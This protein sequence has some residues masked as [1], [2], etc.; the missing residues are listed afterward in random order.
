VEW[1]W[2]AAEEAGL[3]GS[4]DISEHYR[5]ARVPVIAMLQSDMTGYVDPTRPECIGVVGDRTDPDLT[6]FLKRVIK[7]Y[8]VLPI[9]DM[10]C[11]YG[12]SD[13][14]SWTQAGF[15]SAFHFEG[16]SLHVNKHVHTTGDALE[17]IDFGHLGQFARVVA[18]YVMELAGGMIRDP[19]D[20]VEETDAGLDWIDQI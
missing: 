2:Y 18:G 6:Q 19:N 1:H 3:L 9:R 7:K 11:G 8:T 4:Q 13:H 12:C 10:E 20:G 14:A 16:D 15:P 5:R 17:T